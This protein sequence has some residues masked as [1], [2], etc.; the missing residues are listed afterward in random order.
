MF[1]IQTRTNFSGIWI[2]FLF[3]FSGF[4]DV[5][6]DHVSIHTCDERSFRWWPWVFWHQYRTWCLEC[7][8]NYLTFY[9]REISKPLFFY[10]KSGSALKKI[11]YQRARYKIRFSKVFE[12]FLIVK[13]NLLRLSLHVKFPYCSKMKW[14][15]FI[16]Q[17]SE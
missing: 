3:I 5:G 7:K 2:N 4:F 15:Y 1:E 17:F 12:D 16:S 14:S 8:F 13:N 9:L 6:R 11:W 10:R